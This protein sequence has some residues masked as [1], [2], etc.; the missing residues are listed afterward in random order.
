M[1]APVK[2]VQ[3]AHC[4]VVIPTRNRPDP[5]R[6]CLLSV[7]RQTRLPSEIIIVD[8]SDDNAT[9]ELV[10]S[11]SAEFPV[12]LVYQRSAAR[13]TAAQRNR[14]AESSRGDIILFL[15]D[16]VVLEPNFIAE[17]MRVF[18]DD[19][20]GEVGGVS[21]THV[22]GVYAPPSRLNALLLRALGGRMEG[23]YA[24]RLVGPAINF[25]PAD[26]LDTIQTVEW[27]EGAAMAYR[28]EAYLAERSWETFAGYSFMED[29]HLSAR[30]ARRYRLL[31]TTRARLLHKGM[32]KSTHQDWAALGESMV[33]NRHAVVMHVLLRRRPGDYLR[34]FAYELLYCTMAQVK[35]PARPWRANLQLL[36]GKL[37]GVAKLLRGESPHR[38]Y[39][40]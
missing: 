39:F 37:R 3:A 33:L 32:G 6:D 23:S 4:S 40:A 29:V 16:D 11:L 35:N 17:I 26:A 1:D 10:G 13:S 18:E 30:V 19:T 7:A 34:F 15:D 12:S 28:R 22:G 21:G 24:G 2:A 38:P 9:E 25:F 36:C 14:G 31:N 27:L 5:L 8:S 20:K